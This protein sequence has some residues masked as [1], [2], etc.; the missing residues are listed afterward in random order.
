MGKLKSHVDIKKYTF[1]DWL[2]NGA[3]KGTNGTLYRAIAV[4]NT[5]PI[6]EP[7]M[8]NMG[9]RKM[10]YHKDYTLSESD[11][12]KIT[13]HQKRAYDI[14]ID[15]ALQLR[16]NDLERNVKKS[17]KEHGKEIITELLA[18]ELQKA[19]T[20][21]DD[22]GVKIGVL[23]GHKKY[24]FIDGETYKKII[25]SSPNTY[26]VIYD[27]ID[28][29]SKKKPQ[30]DRVFQGWILFKFIKYLESELSGYENKLNS[31]A[32]D[33]GKHMKPKTII[34]EPKFFEV[35]DEFKNPTT[36]KGINSILVK[37]LYKEKHEVDGET[38]HLV[39]YKLE[40]SKKEYPKKLT[41]STT[42]RRIKDY[43]NK[44]S[45]LN[46]YLQSL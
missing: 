9:G 26:H 37:K 22:L 43:L 27:C 38:R 14:A 33:R 25:N 39:G 1:D 35:I 24:H 16:I 42:E 19:K 44:E 41:K 10:V 20:E 3:F 31:T 28:P 18:E 32:S 12:A 11:D 34:P 21:L 36:R 30:F 4:D 15:N 29:N 13:E 40:D 5:V 23:R 6:G 17:V 8:H 45:D 46:E 7:G 2:D